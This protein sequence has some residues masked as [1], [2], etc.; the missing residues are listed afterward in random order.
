MNNKLRLMGFLAFILVVSLACNIT[1]GTAPTTPPDT[2]MMDTQVAMAMTLTAMANP[3]VPA[4]QP[5]AGSSNDPGLVNTQVAMAMTQTA[6][7]NPPPAAATNTPEPTFTPKPTDL[8]IAA[9]IKNSNILIYEDI[10][11]YP[12]YLPYVSRALK[13]VDAHKTYV[14]DAMGTFMDELN[15]GTKWDLIIM[16]SETRGSISGEYWDVIKNKVDD[17]TALVA[18]IWYIDAINQGK[19]SPL[20]YQCGVELQKDWWRDYGADRLAFDIN[21]SVSDSPVFNTPN[22][23]TRFAA[24]LTEPAWNGDI[25]DLMKLRSGSNATILASHTPGEGQTSSGLITSCYDGRM[26]LQTFD[27]HDYPTDPMVA[28]WQNYIIY[29]LTNHFMAEN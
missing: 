6:L 2:G 22:K 28:L 10:I 1:G 15:S 12:A 26:I 9:M 7:S 4:A 29:T 25:G 14:G 20:L 19:I 17:G 23:V 3:V 27:S 21:W 11:G 18:E 5:P 13:S 16:A 24:S 8:D